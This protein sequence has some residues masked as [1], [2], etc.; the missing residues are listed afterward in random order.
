MPRSRATNG[1]PVEYFTLDVDR[2]GP[3]IGYLGGQPIA[4]TVVD[5]AGQHYRF[6]GIAPRRSDGEI[7]ITALGSDEW[8]VRPGLVYFL[9]V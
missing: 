9:E 3:T 8:I 5:Y 4:G 2:A 7:D 1:V 6:V